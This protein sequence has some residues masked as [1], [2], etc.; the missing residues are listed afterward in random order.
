MEAKIIVKLP[1]DFELLKE[2]KK[3]LLRLATDGNVILEGLVTLINEIQDQAVDENG[4]DEIDVFED[5]FYN[6]D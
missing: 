2:Q 5:E 3:E 6:T 1:L 4:L